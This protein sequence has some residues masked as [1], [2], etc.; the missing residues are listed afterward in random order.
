[1]A[2]VTRISPWRRTT[3]SGI[4]TRC[5]TGPALSNDHVVNGRSFTTTE[6]RRRRTISES[7]RP[8]ARTRSSR[9]PGGPSLTR[10]ASAAAGPTENAPIASARAQPY[11]WPTDAPRQ[12]ITSPG[13][14]TGKRCSLRATMKSF[15]VEGIVV[16]QQR[17]EGEHHNRDCHPRQHR[18]Q[19]RHRHG[20]A[21][22]KRIDRKIGVWR[23]AERF[24]RDGERL[25]SDRCDAD[26]GPSVPPEE[27]R[28]KVQVPQAAVRADVRRQTDQCY[29]HPGRHRNAEHQG[30]VAE[31]RCEA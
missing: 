15:H 28:R 31:G 13:T 9:S 30:V 14:E 16:D 17:R 10:T 4:R 20:C 12:L 25:V 6:T 23:R 21:Y 24:L 3:V 5:S 22:Q 18:L 26:I 19:A 2:N 8:S 11:S 1:M 29:E 7:M 27:Q